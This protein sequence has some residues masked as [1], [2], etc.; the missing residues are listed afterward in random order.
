MNT[1]RNIVQNLFLVN[2]SAPNFTKKKLLSYKF[3]WLSGF[4]LYALRNLLDFYYRICYHCH[5][6]HD[7]KTSMAFRGKDWES[8]LYKSVAHNFDFCKKFADIRCWYMCFYLYI[9]ISFTYSSF[10]EA[11]WFI[12]RF[13]PSWQLHFYIHCLSHEKKACHLGNFLFSNHQRQYSE[14][15]IQ[16]MTI[17]R[18]SENAR[19]LQL[20]QIIVFYFL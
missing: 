11:L 12:F 5:L 4:F 18:A 20:C 6:I 9:I 1:F 15:A 7:D 16:S 19:P 17:C 13:L 8:E 3:T 14:P 10:I 2:T